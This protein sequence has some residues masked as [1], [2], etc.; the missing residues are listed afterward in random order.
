MCGWSNMLAW[1]VGASANVAVM[2]F[3]VVFLANLYNPSYESK[4][5]HIFLIMEALL[6]LNCLMNVFATRLLPLIDRIEFWWYIS[7]PVLAHVIYLTM[8][9]F[10]GSFF[11][12]SITAVAA[13][14]P[15]QPA[16]FVFGTFINYTGWDNSFVVFMNGKSVSSS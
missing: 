10:L 9:R 1:I 4:P 15:H 6:I 14:N 5:W 12:V 2:T 16:K 3:Q 13:A 7:A 11:I 8:I